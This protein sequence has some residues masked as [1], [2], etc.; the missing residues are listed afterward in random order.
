MNSDLFIA[1]TLVLAQNWELVLALLTCVSWGTLLIF[2]TL[3][4]ITGT[5][6]ADAELTALALGGWPLPS[7]AVSALLLVLRL[8]IPADFISII[9]LALLVVS[10]GFAIRAVWKLISLDFFIPVFIFLFFVFIRLGFLAN[11]VL[12]PYFDSA[13]HYRIIQ[14]LINMDDGSVTTSYYHLGYH[15]IVAAFTSL[16]YANPGQVMLLFGQ[17]ILAAIP[18]PIY[19]FIRL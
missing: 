14:S 18:L 7:L 11:A 5:Q 13:E 6:F 10:T 19:F 2:A 16:T 9:T 1:G 4:K 17:I 15:V 8:F 3:K 12:P